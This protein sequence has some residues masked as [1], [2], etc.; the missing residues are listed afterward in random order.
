MVRIY[1]FPGAWISGGGGQCFP[2]FDGYYGL[3]RSM[4]KWCLGALIP[5]TNAFPGYGIEFAQTGRRYATNMNGVTVI[6][7]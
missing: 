5:P 3:F 6:N 4:L 1:T 7:L 2:R